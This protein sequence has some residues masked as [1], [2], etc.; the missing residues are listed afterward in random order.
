MHLRLPRATRMRRAAHACTMQP[1]NGGAESTQPQRH[2]ADDN[3]GTIRM[4]EVRGRDRES[5][6][7]G[8]KRKKA[9]VLRAVLSIHN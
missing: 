2:Q 8:G 1:L 6:G 4:A 7:G 5:V 3:G 9:G